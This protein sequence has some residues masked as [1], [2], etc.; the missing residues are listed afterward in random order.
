MQRFNI[1][2]VF[3]DAG[4]WSEGL[5][6]SPED[7]F[8]YMEGAFADA[9]MQEA[10]YV[11]ALSRKNR[12]IGRHRVSIGTLTS[13]LVHPREVFRPLILAGASAFIVC[14][15]HP[16]GDPSPSS[17]DISITRRLKEAGAI[18]DMDMTDHIIIGTAED[19]ASGL[20]YYS[21]SEHGLL[22]SS[23]LRHSEI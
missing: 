13:T 20:G 14:H 19:D 6:Q 12:P 11:I 21:F 1:K 2:V 15:N 3:E 10:F 5:I 8:H 17:A 7:V 9:P 18:F 23:S 4:T 16:S 22:E